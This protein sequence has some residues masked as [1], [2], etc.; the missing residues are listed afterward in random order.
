MRASWRT[1]DRGEQ[2]DTGKRHFRGYERADVM[3][4][5]FEWAIMNLLQAASVG[6]GDVSSD[7][8]K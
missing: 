2:R 1:S 7:H 4:Q 5:R 8:M 3:C 6:K